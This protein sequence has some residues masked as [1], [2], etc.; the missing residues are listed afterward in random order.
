MIINKHALQISLLASAIALTGCGSSSSGSDNKDVEGPAAGRDGTPFSGLTIS[1]KGGSSTLGEGGAGGNIEIYKTNSATD[2]NVVKQGNIDTSY[3]VPTQTPEFG[4]NPVTIAATQ[5]ILLVED[6]ELPAAGTLYMLPSK[7]RLFKSTG[8]KLVGDDSHE[9]TGLTINE[10]S[11]LILPANSGSTRTYLYFNNDVQNNG[12]ITTEND[13]IST[14]VDLNLTGAAYYGA[15]DIILKGDT[16]NYY[17]QSGG[18]LTLNAY[19]I[20]NSGLMNTSGANKSSENNTGNGGGNA[21][22]ISLNGI[23]FIETT[24]ELRAN[25]GHSDTDTG[26]NGADINLSAAAIVN[27]GLINSNSGSGNSQNHDSNSSEI[28]LFAARSILNTGSIS[29]KGADASDSGNA[30]KG[31]DIQLYLHENEE[32]A[33]NQS[34]IN[35][36][37]LIVDGGSITGESNGSAGNGG[38]ISIKTALPNEKANGP[39]VFEI[40]G[41]LSANGGSSIEDDSNA[42]IG[43][44]IEIA[45]YDNPSSSAETFILGYNEINVSGGNGVYAGKAG[46]ID[47]EFEDFRD[48]RGGG[49]YMPTVSAS[50]YNNVDLI[51]N[52]GST[53]AKALEAGL[54]PIYGSGAKGGIVSINANNYSAYL[55]S[56]AINVTNEGLINVNG[57][58]SY[59]NSSRDAEDSAHGGDVLLSAAHKVTV[60][61]PINM[62]GGSD[63]HI[64]TTGESDEHAGSNAGAL[65]LFSQYEQTVVNTDIS[66]NGGQGDLIG[67]HAGMVMANSKLAIEL[68]GTIS[69]NG[70]NTIANDADSFETEGGNAGYVTAVAES[71][72]SQVTS[73]I[74][75][76]AGTGD[77]M[78]E[79]KIIYVDADCLSNNCQLDM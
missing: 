18:D 62:N 44:Q 5:T 47:I 12:V 68:S 72:D 23:V 77:N 26:T 11:T 4:T 38:S 15:G 73:V 27:T 60:T 34:I 3:V 56:G 30:G 58:D 29:S 79:E 32:I 57:G 50:I 9:V 54:D 10:G 40:S 39:M 24:G 13:S 22:S 45:N 20:I 78:G 74:T 71:M 31:G 35:T 64:A 7:F 46:S 37:D 65:T 70:G 36:G 43:G 59:N 6:S 53:N 28:N 42:G 61:Q 51:A 14:R 66:A 76:N 48:K 55:Q 75:A 17:R 19:T 2:L 21:G 8:E 67:G 52:G 63:L 25:G 49:T 33:Y 1:A 69:L 16:S 41:N